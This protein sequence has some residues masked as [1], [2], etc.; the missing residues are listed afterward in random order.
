VIPFI[1]LLAERPRVLMEA[2]VLERLH[3]IEGIVLDDALA[4]APLIYQREPRALMAA[5]YREY[6]DIAAA[7]ELPLLLCSPTWRCNRERVLQWQTRSGAGRASVDSI[8]EDAVAFLR[9]LRAEKTRPVEP[10]SIGG[11]LGCRND[12]YQPQQALSAAA[13]ESFHAWQAQR[14]AAAGVDF[15]IAETLPETFEALGMASALA[16]THLPYVISFVIGQ[17]GRILDGRSLAEAFALIDAAVTTPPVGYMVNCAHPRFLRADDQPA[18]MFSRLI[19]SQANASSLPQQ[20]L[21]QASQVQV[22]DI[23]QWAIE[24]RRL[25]RSFGVRVL[26]GCCGTDS[27][28]LRCLVP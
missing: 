23:D 17:N 21:E 10:L 18:E 13:A 27:R 6:I 16:K 4:N 7:A 2:A 28:H 12:C 14:L 3:R 24:M 5:I 9:D 8:N 20:Q 11:M 19:G 15:L 25:N 26:G 1:D 22:D